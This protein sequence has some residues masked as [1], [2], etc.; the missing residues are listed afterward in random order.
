MS[1]R[2]GHYRNELA[3]AAP[4]VETRLARQLPVVE[5]D[6]IQVQQVMLNLLR[7]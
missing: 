6:R 3:R 4:T 2:A 5:A 7:N 1:G